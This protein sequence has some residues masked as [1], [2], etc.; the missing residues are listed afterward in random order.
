MLSV[1]FSLP[2]KV[3][4]ICWNHY[5]VIQVV[6]GLFTSACK[7]INKKNYINGTTFISGDKF[8]AHYKLKSALMIEPNRFTVITVTQGMMHQYLSIYIIGYYTF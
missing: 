5:K 3:D 8:K 1:L 4:E 6:L 7:K 2:N